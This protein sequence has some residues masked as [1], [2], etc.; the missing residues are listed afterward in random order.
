MFFTPEK[1]LGRYKNRRAKII[2]HIKSFNPKVKN[3]ALLTA[4]NFETDR[5]PFKQESSF[6]YLSGIME[7]ATVLC[8][9]FNGPEIVYIPFYASSRE[10]WVKTDVSI[11]S[12]AEDFSVDQIRYLGQE[13]KGHSCAP[14]FTPERYGELIADLKKNLGPGGVIYTLLDSS[15]SRYFV[16][17]QFIARLQ[18]WLLDQKVS[19]QDVSNI[20]HHLRRVK[21]GYEVNLIYK[22]VQ[23]T[24]KAM[25]AAAKSIQ[26]GK[27]EYQIQALIEYVF[28]EA[29]S[30][31]PAFPSIVATGINTT[32]LH[33]CDR[34]E[35]MKD[36]DLVVIDIG[37]EYG[38]YSSD[39]T[40]TF[41]V[42]GSF[43]SRQKEIYNI[44]LQ[45][46]K[47]IESMA[48]PGMFLNNPKLPERSLHH[49][50]IK[51]LNKLGYAQYFVHGIGHFLGLDVHDVGSN[52]IELRPG[53]VFTI[54]PG[55]YIPQENTGVRIEDDYAMT[56]EG[57]ICLSEGLPKSVDDVEKMMKNLH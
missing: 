15:N 28:K 54:E 11:K 56:N 2:E 44:V 17:M 31:D 48:V 34:N 4:S 10:Q 25:Q 24:S 42:S 39:L 1:N 45:T 6:Y 22:A 23:I 9:F 35:Q 40:R 12:R 26:P 19:I 29:A 14:L 43:S 53:D 41:P 8:S 51:F 37:A 30:V 46:Q 7:P 21:E 49:Q 57:A 33:S 13:I 5:Y 47:H 20:V 50:A 32:I 16:Q 36:G 55:I 3:A 52:E 27:Y 38:N 18:E